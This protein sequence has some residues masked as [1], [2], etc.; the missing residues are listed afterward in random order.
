MK[1][2]K[3]YQ[4]NLSC[5]VLRLRSNGRRVET[6][7]LVGQGLE[8]TGSVASHCSDS[9]CG[10]VSSE[11]AC[12]SPSIWSKLNIFVSK[13]GIGHL[14]HSHGCPSSPTLS[15]SRTSSESGSPRTVLQEEEDDTALEEELEESFTFDIPKPDLSE[16]LDDSFS[17]DTLKPK[18]THEAYVY[19][20]AGLD[21][22]SLYATRRNGGTCSTAWLA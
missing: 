16:A 7:A 1:K 19:A 20:A 11:P 2:R 8:K 6:V 21:D 22:Y 17:F 12:N 10:S 9:S 15:S 14:R 5:H 13:S 3:Y 4:E 18:P